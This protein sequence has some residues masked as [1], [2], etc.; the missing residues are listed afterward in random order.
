MKA[1]LS[2]LEFERRKPVWSVLS[3]FWLDDQ[4]SETDE[5]R[6]AE[7]LL[8]S[9]YSLAE[10]DRVLWHEVAPV[11]FLNCY[12]AAGAWGMF[13]EDWLH[14]QTKRRAEC[15]DW[16]VRVLFELRIG[17]KIM[18]MASPESWKQVQIILSRTRSNCK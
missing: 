13:D 16:F 7:I 12:V 4:L 17:K 10:I 9:C 18:S 11:V 8:H 15:N 3:E 1:K 2:A 14:S 5:N 6:I